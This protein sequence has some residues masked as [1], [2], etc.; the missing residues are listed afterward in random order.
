[1]DQDVPCFD[2]FPSPTNL[3]QP[4]PSPILLNPTSS[5]P[6]FDSFPD[7]EPP[8]NSNYSDQRRRHPSSKQAVHQLD[9]T[10]HIVEPV[11]DTS[12]TPADLFLE[13]LDEELSNQAGSSANLNHPA[14]EKKTKTK[15]QSKNKTT[16]RKSKE[17]SLGVNNLKPGFGQKNSPQSLTPTFAE[18]SVGRNSDGKLVFALD[19]QEDNFNLHHGRPDRSRVPNYKRATAGRVLGLSPQL[20]IAFASAYSGDGLQL[21]Q[22]RCSKGIALSD[23]AIL[24]I[25]NDKNLKRIL[26]LSSSD[27]PRQQSDF[28]SS[29]FIP[30]V[31][32]NQKSSSRL[33]PN[34]HQS[35]LPPLG[36]SL[37]DDLDS[38]DENSIDHVPP[39]YDGGESFLDHLNRRK[40]QLEKHVEQVPSDVEAWLELVSLQDEMKEL[41]LVGLRARVTEV[42]QDAVRRHIRGTSDLKLSYLKQ[43][44]QVS[45]N[46]HNERL[47]LAYIKAYCDQPDINPAQEW[48]QMLESHP[49]ITALWIAYVDWRQT[50]A[51]SFNVFEMVEVYEELIDRLVRRAE[52]YNASAKDRNSYEQNIVYLF[53]RCCVMLRQAGYTER[54]IAAF[55]AIMEVNFSCPVRPVQSLNEVIEEF[56]AFWDSEIPRIGELGAKG[57][58]NSKLDVEL[59]PLNS[60]E[61][62]H[63]DSMF[64]D[65]SLDAWKNRELQFQRPLRTFH[66][67]ND[68]DPFGCVLFDDLRNLLFLVSSF[69]S[70]QALL[71]SFLSFI[72]I[73]IPPPDVDTNVPYFNDSFL[74]SELIDYPERQ[75]S[76]W[77]QL[78]R[79]PLIG[80]YGAPEKLSGIKKP[81]SIPFRVFPSDLR[82]LFAQSSDWFA[83][84]NPPTF[85]VE[86]IRNAFSFLRNTPILKNDVYFKLCE[87][88]FE[89]QIDASSA[90]KLA[91]QMLS[92]DQLN[93]ILWDA[94][95]RICL[96]R[97]KPKQARDVYIKALEILPENTD[98]LILLWYSWAEMEFQLGY[99]A[100]VV[101]ILTRAMNYLT[102][103]PSML[104]AHPTLSRSPAVL[105]C[106]RRAFTGQIAGSFHHDVPAFVLRSRISTVIA[107][108]NFQ[109]S[110]EGFTSAC[111]VF[112]QSL[113]AISRLNSPAEEEELWVNFCRCIYSHILSH[114]GYKP[115]EIRGILKRAVEKFPNNSIFFS[116]FAFN[117]SKMKID[118][119]TRRLI[120]AT[121]LKHT[122]LTTMNN[123]LYAIWVE[124]H[125]NVSG[126]S[127]TAVRAL[128]ERAVTQPSTRSCL[129]IWRLYIEFEIRNENLIRAKSLITRS[130]AACPWSK[131]LYLLPFSDQLKAV[132]SGISDQKR[133]LKLLDEKGIR[134]KDRSAHC[135]IEQLEDELNACDQEEDAIE[136]AERKEMEE[137]MKL[138]PY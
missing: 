134:I 56:E 42:D 81:Q 1:M 122:S 113:M 82:Q 131:E 33:P 28:S 83:S 126:Y 49:S 88:S 115:L 128:F 73:P 37:F 50:E 102:D 17:K 104:A 27:L 87:L 5:I 29:P 23:P 75:S 4:L 55:Q 123:W 72:G 127:Q 16:K 137:R 35:D 18:P 24:N 110:T 10:N 41:G 21:S 132:Y 118:N 121:L 26:A 53:H 13:S 47:L 8:A 31:D 111:E 97:S 135:V 114:Q 138:F 34:N 32:P 14:R 7:P 94:Y 48:R 124:I 136:S 90:T 117:E 2:S 109:F 89:A 99:S 85:T 107:F 46:Q 59:P 86:F 11:A 71:Y 95:A 120:D 116:L 74:L 64:K 79:K 51:G 91:K 44:L 70:R 103:S 63:A 112:D 60:N 30:L 40:G 3:P 106:V 61:S 12:L 43:A 66:P 101:S 98:D 52:D 93:L 20:R 19:L 105:L 39:E 67:Q 9:L 119:E 54:A 6:C 84:F 100:L 80:A 96:L 108:A 45:S 69:D 25:L 65:R 38:D 133:M 36:I 125:L 62:I 129:Q 76:F 22:E 92:E 58:A 68:E 130:H 77:P 15:S 57:W 78:E